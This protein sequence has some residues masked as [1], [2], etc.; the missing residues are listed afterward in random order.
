VT[1]EP[2]P[3]TRRLGLGLAL[4]FV[5]EGVRVEDEEVLLSFGRMGEVSREEFAELC[6][7]TGAERLSAVDIRGGTRDIEG[8][9]WR[10]AARVS[11]SEPFPLRPVLLLGSVEATEALARFDFAVD[12]EVGVDPLE[13]AMASH[14]G[15]PK[16]RRHASRIT[17][18]GWRVRRTRQAGSREV[19]PSAPDRMTETWGCADGQNGQ[20]VFVQ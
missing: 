19:W 3:L 15:Q 5:R 11:G 16:R 12:L 17:R 1:V 13:E 6:R 9:F 7:V 2:V 8:G 14:R 18:R 4:C 10:G 20:C